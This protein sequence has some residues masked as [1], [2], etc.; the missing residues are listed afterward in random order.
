[1][2]HFIK[3]VLDWF[4]LTKLELL[5]KNNQYHQRRNVYYRSIVFIAV[6]SLI[7][8]IL[9]VFVGAIGMAFWVFFQ[10]CLSLIK[11]ENSSRNVKLCWND[12]FCFHRW[13][14]GWM[15]PERWLRLRK[16][17]RRQIFRWVF[18]IFFWVK[19]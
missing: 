8:I 16:H 7:S 1:M 10:P 4:L 3:K 6:V 14:I 19:L 12:V 17:R 5:R 13:K 18:K 2:E 15:E 9:N 11:L